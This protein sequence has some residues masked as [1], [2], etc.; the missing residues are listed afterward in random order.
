MT[1]VEAAPVRR[2]SIGRA[3]ALSGLLIGA[4][5][6]LGFLRDLTLAHHFGA[7]SGTDAFLVGWTIPETVSP[8]LIEDAMAL[9][10]TPAISYALHR[11]GGV[12]PLVASALSRLAA[13]LALTALLTAVAAPY[14][15]AV[16]APGLDD[17]TD[18]IRC[19]RFTSLTILTFGI[20]GFMA[21]TLRAYH[22]FGPPAAIYAAYN[23]GILAM[24]GAFHGPLGVTSA[25]LGVAI[26]SLLMVAVVTP[27]FARCLTPARTS[28]RTGRGG[29]DGQAAIVGLAALAP[30]VIWSLTR[31]AQTLVERFLG[32]SLAEGSI[33]YL[34][35]AQ[36]VAQVPAMLALLLVTVTFPRLARASADGDVGQV[37]RRMETDVVG[38]GAMVLCST[39]FLVAFAPSVIS[40]LFQHGRFTE[41]D[42]DTTALVMRVY[43]LGLLGQAMVAVAGRGFFAHRTPRWYPVLCVAVGLVVTAVVGVATLGVFGVAGLA[44][45]NALGISVAAVLLFVG[46]RTRVV[47]LSLRRTGKDFVTLLFATAPATAVGYL[48]QEGLAERM[49]P[50]LLLVLGG[51]VLLAVFGTALLVAC[52]Y[53]GFTNS[54]RG[55]ATGEGTSPLEFY[56]PFVVRATSRVVSRLDRGGVR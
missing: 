31:Q 43:S 22:C 28:A 35:Y 15:V 54:A 44:A 37:R 1:A 21:A 55:A 10:V 40:I 5:T 2:V 56:F 9:A 17:P 48:L 45:A 12:R 41:S 36:K 25:A 39:A 32:S 24:I 8:L 14:L 47:P 52:A 6:L 16:L 18:A 34:N 27:T 38:V 30:I 33:S 23:V 7:T 46:M 11:H 26:G 4:G 49:P 53:R 3:T 29:A 20:A 42:T 13:L 51:V 50:V 19:V